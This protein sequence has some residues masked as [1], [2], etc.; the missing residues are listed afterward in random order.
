MLSITASG[1]LITLFRSRS[2]TPRD[3]PPSDHQ[4][5][6]L[7]RRP[8]GDGAIIIHPARN[9]AHGIVPK[10]RIVIVAQLIRTLLTLEELVQRT[11][12]VLSALAATAADAL[13]DRQDAIVQPHA[14]ELVGGVV[15]VVAVLF[16]CRVGA[17]AGDG[18]GVR[19]AAA[20]DFDDEARAEGGQVAEDE[21]A[22]GVGWVFG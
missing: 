3:L 16:R 11:Q 6:H 1:P 12:A 15:G 2:S 20:D 14:H 22:V 9:I 8:V 4:P 21:V 10:A 17:C 5:P 18:G 13:V 7:L 19:L